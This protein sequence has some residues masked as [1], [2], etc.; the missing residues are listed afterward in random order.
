VAR[1]ALWIVLAALV[2]CAQGPLTDLD[3]LC[4]IFEERP[5]WRESAVRAGDRWGVGAPIQL[6]FVHQ[7][8]RFRAEARPA[9]KRFLGIPLWRP[10]SAYGYGQVS[11]GTWEMYLE[12]EQRRAKRD[13]FEDVADFIG[14]Y[15]NHIHQMTGIP[16]DDAYRLYLAYHE[17]PTGFRRGS[18]L[19]KPWLLQVASKVE[20]RA[21]RYAEQRERC[22][23]S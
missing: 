15:A 23:K 16:K 19:E 6:A 1:S 11:D 10:S 8:S 7:E 18:Y 2:G 22:R 17:G 3:D 13:R 12:R 20:A 4:R 9:R 21:E 5:K 14:W